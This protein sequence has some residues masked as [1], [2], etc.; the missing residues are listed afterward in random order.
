MKEGIYRWQAV[1]D[2]S[3]SRTGNNQSLNW[4]S[5]IGPRAYL[6]LLLKP[7]PLLQESQQL[8]SILIRQLAQLVLSGTVILHRTVN[9]PRCREKM[10]LRKAVLARYRRPCHRSGK[11]QKQADQ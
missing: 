11:S 1:Q 10:I 9:N 5:Q 3:P 6:Q 2:L 7:P 8:A 4:S